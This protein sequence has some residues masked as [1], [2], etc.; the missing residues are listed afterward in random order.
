M[1]CISVDSNAV[2]ALA[3]HNVSKNSPLST[4]VV[5]IRT[6]VSWIG[7]AKKGSSPQHKK[8]HLRTTMG[9]NSSYDDKNGEMINT[10]DHVT[11]S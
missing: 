11:V 9:F 6:K 10:D 5:K 8:G 3:N 7:W 1:S 2:Y 4:I